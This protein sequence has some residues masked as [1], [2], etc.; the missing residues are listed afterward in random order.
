MSTHD[1]KMNKISGKFLKGIPWSEMVYYDETSPTG[2][3]HKTD[4]RYGNQETLVNRYADEVAGSV[5][6]G[7][8]SVYSSTK[9]GTFQVHKIIWYLCTGQDVPENHIID[10]IDGNLQNNSISNLRVV[11]KALNARNASKYKNNTTGITGIYLDTKNKGQT[12]WKASWMALD[13][14]QKTKSFSINK[15]GDESAKLLAMA[16]R[17]EQI[18]LLNEQGAGYSDRH[19][20]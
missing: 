1:S 15:L 6:E 11:S 18:R 12:Y 10:H 4:K 13:G 16:Y 14:K 19:G 5:S 2:L 9:Y 7:K 20:A 3:R 17:A 8:Y